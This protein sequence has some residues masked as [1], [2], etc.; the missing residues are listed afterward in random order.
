MLSFPLL[1]LSRLLRCLRSLSVELSR[2]FALSSRGVGA[3]PLLSLPASLGGCAL[4]EISRLAAF[5][6]SCLADVCP[7]PSP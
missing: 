2:S 6:S 4:F 3:L 1:E 5:V 7:V